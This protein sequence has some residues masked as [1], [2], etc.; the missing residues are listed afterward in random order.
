[1]TFV[2]VTGQPGSGKSTVA[3]PLAERL[4]MSLLAKDTVKE[5][6]AVLAD[7]ESIDVDRSQELGRASFEVI[8]ALASQSGGAV[9]EASWNPVYAGER[10]AALP[11]PIIELHCQCPPEVARRRY[12][13]RASRRHWVHL[14]ATRAH[15]ASL[16]ASP[17]PLGLSDPV[18]IVDTTGPTDIAAVAQE[19][20]N[21]T[22][23]G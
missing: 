15:D 3:V 18:I 21:H 6:L 11:A 22:D 17:G 16:W 2:V 20:T 14:D 8:F 19:L 4:R 9:L 13:E 23:W 5:A 1:M 10:L 12:V 7:P